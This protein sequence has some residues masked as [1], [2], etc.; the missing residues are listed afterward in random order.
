MPR[1]A[2]VVT[3]LSLPRT[4]AAPPSEARWAFGRPDAPTSAKRRVPAPKKARRGAAAAGSKPGCGRLGLAC[5]RLSR[6][7][8]MAG[9]AALLPGLSGWQMHAA[10]STSHLC[11][12]PAGWPASTSPPSPAAPA[13]SSLLAAETGASRCRACCDLAAALCVACACVFGHTDRL[14]RCCAPAL[15]AYRPS[16]TSGRPSPTPTPTPTAHPHPRHPSTTHPHSAPSS[17]PTP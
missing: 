9:V 11:R 8:S 4:C 2:G 14:A 13:P 16:I 7:E 6:E 15:A 3:S 12:F 17:P 5:Q 1:C 10:P